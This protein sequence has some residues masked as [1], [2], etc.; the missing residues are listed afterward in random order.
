MYLT[1]WSVA[2]ALGALAFAGAAQAATTYDADLADPGV[3]FGTGNANGHFTVETAGGYEL[4]LRARTYPE[5]AVAPDH[6]NVYVVPLG[7]VVSFDWSF[8]PGAESTAA[9]FFSMSIENLATGGTASF[10]PAGVLDNATS[11]DAVGGFQNSWRLSFGF[12]N[13]GPILDIPFVIFIPGLGDID[14]D[15]NVDSS[16]KITFGVNGAAAG[17]ISNTI[18]VNQG[19]GAAVPEPATWAMMIMGF[20]AAGALLRR[21]RTAI[22]AA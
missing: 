19:A 9:L 15:A 3:Y 5:A 6:D 14:Y 7:D 13:G 16:Y 18:Y 11:P 2:G 17:P 1:R 21:R 4:G 8:N 20:G 12:L 10:S 22:L